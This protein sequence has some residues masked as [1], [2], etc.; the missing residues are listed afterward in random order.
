MPKETKKKKP[1]SKTESFKRRHTQRAIERFKK[2]EAKC[3]VCKARK[4]AF[5]KM[6]NTRK[7]KTAIIAIRQY[8]KKYLQCDLCMEKA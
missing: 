6:M 2:K 4:K 3:P 1:Q 5:K 8:W 7:K